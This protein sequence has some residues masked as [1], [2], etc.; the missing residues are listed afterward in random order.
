MSSRKAQKEGNINLLIGFTYYSICAYEKHASRDGY[1][2]QL[3]HVNACLPCCEICNAFMWICRLSFWRNLP[4]AQS[5]KS[6]ISAILL[7]ESD[8]KCRT[9]QS[10]YINRRTLLQKLSLLSLSGARL[11]LTFLKCKFSAGFRAPVLGFHSDQP[12][13]Q[14]EGQTECE[15][16]EGGEVEE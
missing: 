15:R 10:Q 13:Q 1:I 3:D 16:K 8:S 14:S 2:A 11:T 7:Q 6:N 9:N 12:S 5:K 4:G